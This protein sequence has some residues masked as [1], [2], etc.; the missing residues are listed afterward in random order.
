M[1]TSLPFD[2]GR[3][4]YA[5]RLRASPHDPTEVRGE[6]E[7]V[8]SGER[9]RFDSP[10][11]LLAALARLQSRALRDPAVAAPVPPGTRQSG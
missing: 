6:L 10:A 8:L 9:E 4:T 7:H 3:Q 1:S 11:A 5:L 2:P